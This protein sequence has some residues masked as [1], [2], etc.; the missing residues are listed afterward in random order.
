MML[1]SCVTVFVSVDFF[2]S[3]L[4]EREMC[5]TVGNDYFILQI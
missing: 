4:F 1:E 5:S 3:I 2:V